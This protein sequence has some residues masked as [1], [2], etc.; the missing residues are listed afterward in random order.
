MYVGHTIDW[1]R[2]PRIQIIQIKGGDFLQNPDGIDLYN[3][4][5]WAGEPAN[6]LFFFIFFQF[7]TFFKTTFWGINA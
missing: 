5:R 2:S 4:V 1:L 7:L 3:M 6:L